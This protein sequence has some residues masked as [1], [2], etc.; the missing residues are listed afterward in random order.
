MT[1]LDGFFRLKNALFYHGGKP[2]DRLAGPKTDKS[3][4]PS[5]RSGVKDQH[6]GTKKCR[7]M[8]RKKV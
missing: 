5:A 4:P 3:I 6:G 7:E 2:L 1:F 8:E